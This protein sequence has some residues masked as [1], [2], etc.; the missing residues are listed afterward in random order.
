MT[1]RRWIADE[2]SGDT[3]A[4]VGE[5]AAHLARVLRAEVGQE[6]DIATG[7]DIRRGTITTI[8]YDRVEFALG[9]KA[10]RKRKLTSL[11]GPPK[12]T[13]ALAIFKF[14]RMEW[15]IEKCTEIGV[16]RI[17]PVI[18]RRSDAHLAAAAVKRHER[19]LRIVRQAAEQSRR[20]APPEI[21]APVK[22]KELGS[23]VSAESATRVVLAESEED[24]RL[25]DALQSSP[26][27]IAL[28]VGPEGGWAD[29][30]LSWFYDE[31]W[32]AAS[33]GDTILRAE[34]AAIVA[35]ALAL[36]AVL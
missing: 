14:D 21:A 15:A 4:L 2:V 13:L 23:V 10:H 35:T 18:A 30:E 12:I 27:E 36:E 25:A 6:F 16:A 3:A 22:L 8:S 32:L 26:S 5:H 17:I 7:D 11:S 31:G 24:T 28:A 29:G 1:R 34:T 9:V 19:W 20:A 33:L